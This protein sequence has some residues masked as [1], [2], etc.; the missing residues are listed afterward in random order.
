MEV[1]SGLKKAPEVRELLKRAK[2]GKVDIL[3][4]THKLLGGEVAFKDLG[5]L[6]VD[7]EQLVGE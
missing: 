3:I 4:G 1:I 2:E 5:L 6:V 7:E